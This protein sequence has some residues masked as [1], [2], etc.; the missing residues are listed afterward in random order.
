MN[1]IVA[2]RH[3]ENDVLSHFKLD[4]GRVLSKEEAV[5]DVELGLI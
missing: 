3:G 5:K 1:K 4:G 2:V